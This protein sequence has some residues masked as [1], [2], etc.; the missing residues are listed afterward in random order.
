MSFP[1]EKELWQRFEL[2][3]VAVYFATADKK[4]RYYGFGVADE[5]FSRDIHEIA[6][7]AAGK[8]YPVFGGVP[9][10]DQL[11]TATMM[12][13]YFLQPK[14][15]YDI[16]EQHLWGYETNVVTNRSKRRRPEI[17]RVVDETNWVQRVQ[18]AIDAMQSDG[19]KQKVVLGR[20][21]QVTL[22]EP[23]DMAK[24]IADLQ[25]TQPHNYHFVLK[26]GNDIFIS[27]TPERL[28]K[29]NDGHLATAG[30]AGTA[31]RGQD[32]IE[33]LQLAATLLNDP[34]NLQEHAI[35]VNRI[36]ERLAGMAALTVPK[37]PTIMKNPQVQHLYTPI[38][39]QVNDGV[40]TLSI[41]DRLHPTPALG[42][43]PEEWALTQIAQL[44]QN[45]R[46]LFAA[47]VGVLRP[48]GDGEMV[49]GIRSMFAHA[50]KV[51]LFAGAGILADSDATQEYEET[52]LKMQPMMKLLER[53][54]D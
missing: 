29:I 37:G 27:A 7:W 39:G 24:L 49:V 22:S 41:V 46:G 16:A 23:L 36:V 19:T 11:H 53:Q 13:G 35:V 34:K 6:T 30:V 43:Q 8:N 40:T 1:S 28:V 20:Q 51:D 17:E 42:G 26:R 15:L 18:H 45:P 47:P 44:E 48:S 14:V 12:N 4:S 50:G 31:R 3:E 32:E 52:A 21:R 10:D 9:F 38:T 33:D 5:I 54:H 25:M 2:A